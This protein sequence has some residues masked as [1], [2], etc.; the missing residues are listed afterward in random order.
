[1]LLIL[2][3]FFFLRQKWILLSFLETNHLQQWQDPYICSF[4]ELTLGKGKHLYSYIVDLYIL[5]GS[6]TMIYILIKQNT[7]FL[8]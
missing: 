5:A 7:A 4:E 6:F 2:F 1:M 8:N 3:F